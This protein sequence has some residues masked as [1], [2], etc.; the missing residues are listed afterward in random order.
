M[1]LRASA[2][3]DLRAGARFYEGQARGL[4]MQFLHALRSELALLEANGTIYPKVN[5]GYHRLVTRRFPF[6][7]FY[8]IVDDTVEVS[9]IIDC[10]RD[11]EWI[12]E[13]LR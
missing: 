7:I 8:R 1:R 5:D 11:P 3:E 12:D 9:A 4:G 10:R 2:K 13:R 6:A